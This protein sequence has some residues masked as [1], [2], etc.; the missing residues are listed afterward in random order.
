MIGRWPDG[1][2]FEDAKV[3]AE[4]FFKGSDRDA[5]GIWP[6]SSLSTVGRI[7]GRR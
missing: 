1:I 5:P 7:A 6:G 4:G 3:P 2:R